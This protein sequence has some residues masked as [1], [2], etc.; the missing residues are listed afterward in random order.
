VDTSTALAADLNG[1]SDALNDGNVDGQLAQ[2]MR[3]MRKDA[4]GAVHSLVGFSITVSMSGQDVTLTSLGNSVQ[5]A[6]V[7]VSLRVPFDPRATG[8][9]GA[10][11]FYAAQAGAF[12]TLADELGRLLGA[13]EQVLVPDA[14]VPPRLVSGLTGAVELSVINRALGVLIEMGYTPAE[15][16]HQLRW[17]AD[18][19]RVSLPDVAQQLL[20]SL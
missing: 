15:A 7:V 14:S 12:D 2:S 16:Q 10:A 3:A 6:D 19:S 5:S 4:Q 1:L 18:R 20:S 17:R 8:I 11:T 9:S 13:P